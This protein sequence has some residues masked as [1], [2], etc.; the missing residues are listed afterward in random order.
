MN[1]EILAKEVTN[2]IEGS[3]KKDIKIVVETV[4]ETIADALVA[5]EKVS[6]PGFGTFE[7]ADRAAR[8]ARNP[9]TGEEIDVPASKAPKFKAAKALKDAVKNA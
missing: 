7:V 6:I 8:K 2:K 5:G 4:F 9:Q 1:K 3:T